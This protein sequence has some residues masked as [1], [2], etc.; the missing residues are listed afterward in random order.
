MVEFLVGKI[1]GIVENR[2]EM[3]VLEQKRR[4]I[5]YDTEKMCCGHVHS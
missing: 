5:P 4:L 2:L 3:K 1:V